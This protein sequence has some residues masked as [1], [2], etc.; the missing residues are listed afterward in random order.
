MKLEGAGEDISSL[1]ACLYSPIHHLTPPP[2]HLSR[3]TCAHTLFPN[4]FFHSPAPSSSIYTD[5]LP[6]FVPPLP[7]PHFLSFRGTPLPSCL[8]PLAMFT[9]PPPPDAHVST[10]PPPWPVLSAGRAGCG[11]HLFLQMRR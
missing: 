5:Q 10:W 9:S 6:E 1:L 2:S 3:L 11:P 7:C 4:L 8:I